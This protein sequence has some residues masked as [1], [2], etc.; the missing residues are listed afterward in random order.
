MITVG[1]MIKGKK[2]INW[3][4]TEITNQDGHELLAEYGEEEK[5]EILKACE[6]FFDGVKISDPDNAN[7]DLELYY[8]FPDEEEH[9]SEIGDRMVNLDEANIIVRRL[10]RKKCER[11]CIY[12]CGGEI[13][14]DY[15]EIKHFQTGFLPPFNS[16]DVTL[17]IEDLSDFGYSGYI[18]SG[19]RYSGEDE[20]FSESNV[21]PGRSLNSRLLLD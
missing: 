3:Y 6:D 21:T 8:Y 9:P 5:I 19:I 7:E 2:E 20:I 17:F 1:F 13:G 14:E 11:D 16:G 4:G 12:L 18:L 15:M 10:A